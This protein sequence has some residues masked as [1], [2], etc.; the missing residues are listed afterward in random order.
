MDKNRAIY[1]GLVPTRKLKNKNNF[2]LFLVSFIVFIGFLTIGIPLPILPLH[3]TNTLFFG[4]TIAGF[5]IGSQSIATLVTRMYAGNLADTQGSKKTVLIGL[6]LCSFVG[7]FYLISLSFI[8]YKKI[9]LIILI[10]GRFLLGFGESM[11]MTGALSWGINLVG[12]HYSAKVMSWM[13]LALYAAL[14]IGAPI[15]MELI[16]L[17]GLILIS[18]IVFILPIISFLLAS[19][20]PGT[21]IVVTL[22][23]NKRLSFLEIMKRIWLPGTGMALGAVGFG[24]IATFM[25]LYYS[26]QGWDG[27]SLC[28]SVF[29]GSYITMRL[30][31]PNIINKFGGTRIAIILLIIET[32]GQLV[33]WNSTNPSMALLG[34]T[35]TGIGYSLILPAF[36]GE[37]IKNVPEQSRGAALGA[38]V[39]FF[40]LALGLTGP[41]FGF[42]IAKIGYTPAFL[43][44]AFA[45]TIALFIAISLL[46][47][48]KIA[49][50]Q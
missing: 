23:T 20:I 33:I 4:S 6:V 45:T 39:A 3:V 29:A 43:G 26:S 13:G 49:G 50:G 14:A 28:L 25:T 11:V 7:I 42:M 15:G 10:I 19:K 47:N 35:L 30:I 21:P 16:K 48:G 40:D 27:A 1:T 41:L 34:A 24:L 2:Y 44:G 9:S 32:I 17:N 18:L 5:V 12:N 46:K 37:V 22:I 38:Y 36:G 31:F 8:E